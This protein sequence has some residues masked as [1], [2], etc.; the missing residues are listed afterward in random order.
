MAFDT[1]KAGLKVITASRTHKTG[2]G[3][4][5]VK[6]GTSGV[7]SAILRHP[8]TRAITGVILDMGTGDSDD[9]VVVPATALRL[10]S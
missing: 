2:R 8:V 4:I 5:F 10:A 6:G 7:V 9:N 3:F 1:I